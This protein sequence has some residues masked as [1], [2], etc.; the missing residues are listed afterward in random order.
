MSSLLVPQVLAFRVANSPPDAIS[1]ESLVELV[2]AWP[3][4]KPMPLINF[5]LLK[6]LC[7]TEEGAAVSYFCVPPA[8]GAS[9]RFEMYTE[10][11]ELL[12]VFDK[13]FAVIRE[14]QGN[15]SVT[16]HPTLHDAKQQCI[17]QRLRR[18]G[19]SDSKWFIAISH[20]QGAQPP[21]RMKDGG[22]LMPFKED[23]PSRVCQWID[24]VNHMG[25]DQASSCPFTKAIPSMRQYR[26][27]TAF[28]LPKDPHHTNED[29]QREEEKRDATTPV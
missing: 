17:C 13:R 4:V 10:R 12:T 1:M 15:H 18:H 6:T 19:R 8:L 11:S 9:E 2:E 24:N 29:H 7:E 5:T 16:G 21:A 28:K 22:R 27:R 23:G 25:H 20:L 3:K 14:R 26:R